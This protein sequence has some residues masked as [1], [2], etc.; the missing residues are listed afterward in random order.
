[1]QTSEEHLSTV[2]SIVQKWFPIIGIL[3]IVSGLSYFFYDGIWQNISET[4]RLAIGFIAGLLLIAGGYT[5]SEKLRIF[6]DAV[7]GGGVL[8]FYITLIY[9]SRFESVKDTAIIPELWSLGIAIIFS[10]AI[11]FYATQR[12]SKY[13]LLLG[14]LGAYLTPLFVAHPESAIRFSSDIY[15]DA[16]SLPFFSYLFY[17]TAINVGYLVASTHM[18][19]KKIGVINA[20]GLFLGTL[21]VSAIMGNGFKEHPIISATLCAIIVGLHLFA[22][23]QN[24]KFFQKESDPYLIA[25]YLL[26]LGWYALIM[27]TAI[28]DAL[29]AQTK[30]LFFLAVCFFYFSAWHYLRKINDS[31][32]H[33]A[34]YVG[35]VLS[36]LL[37]LSALAPNFMEYN[38]IVASLIGLVFGVLYILRPVPQREISFLLFVICGIILTLEYITEGSIEGTFW[39]LEGTFLSIFQKTTLFLSATLSPFLLSF[40]FPRREDESHELESFRKIG[41]FLSVFII[42]FLFLKDIFHIIEIP[43]Q[44]IYF[45]IPSAIIAITLFI[46]KDTSTESISTQISIA[47]LLAFIGYFYTFFQFLEWFYPSPPSNNFPLQTSE[48][49]I[50]LTTVIALFLLL[51]KK[52]QITNESKE[53]DYFL[54]FFFYLTVFQLITNEI[55]S[56]Y[57]YF[58]EMIQN[59]SIQGIRAF[60]ISLWWGILAGG[61]I[62]LGIKSNKFTNE[63]NLGL[64]LIFISIL[65]IFFYD[66]SHVDTNLKV[67]LFL[68]LGSIILAISYFAHKKKQITVE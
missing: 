58:P 23:A 25:G 44:Y 36:L 30:A 42:L 43:A 3:F 14:M 62:F 13:I 60:S 40:F 18:S 17:F 29:T 12:S 45:T 7:I 37:G 34:L 21:A 63:K 50:A 15:G 16:N 6:A 33:Y 24:S 1:M 41:A 10:L 2:D 67:F 8:I 66:L 46:K 56:A 27:N 49:L 53:N 54:T 19:L 31:G 64:G 57:N 5:F 61:M 51:K 52:R 65:K 4:G 38:G 39:I 68:I 59:E 22:M 35:G 48:S 20:L 32:K 55:L 9:G 28:E 11:A 47:T 26:P